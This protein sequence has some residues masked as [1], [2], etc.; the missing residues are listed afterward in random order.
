LGA[1]ASIGA[2][3]TSDDAYAQDYYSSDLRPR[4]RVEPQFAAEIRFGPY[5]PDVD[6]GVPGY[7][8]CAAN[9][10]C[11]PQKPFDKV[12]GSDKRI[13]ISAEV[14]WEAYHFQRWLTFSLGGLIGYT[15]ASGTAEFA[16]GS[17][18]SAEPANLSIWV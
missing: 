5:L 11:T 10:Q 1:A 4:Q 13:M 18:G 9:A 12:F 8:P 14:D 6:Q 3:A 7:V 17:G 15:K 2:L 16:D